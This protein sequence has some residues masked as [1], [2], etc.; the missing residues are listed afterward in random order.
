MLAS[1]LVQWCRPRGLLIALVALAAV[2]AAGCKQGIGERCEQG[3]DCASGFCNQN[4][5]AFTGGQQGLVC[6]GPPGSNMMMSMDATSGEDASDAASAAGEAGD[7]SSPETSEVSS[8][9]EAG[10]EVGGQGHDGATDA[11]GGGD[12][13]GEASTDARSDSGG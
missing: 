3:S 10:A 5:G 9:A 12:A 1:F 11:A 2:G 8:P 7:V 13:S 6:T 4:Q